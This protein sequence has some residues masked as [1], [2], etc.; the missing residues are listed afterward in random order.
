[1]EG[2]GGKSNSVFPLITQNKTGGCLQVHRKVYDS[3]VSTCW[4]EGGQVVLRSQNSAVST[5]GELSTH[6]VQT[7]SPLYFVFGFGWS[8]GLNPG[9]VLE[10][11]SLRGL[12]GP[13]GC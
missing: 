8:I 9:S 5:G 3:A 1:M 13:L 12:E 11:H 4:G 10:D 7:S 6:L 2:W